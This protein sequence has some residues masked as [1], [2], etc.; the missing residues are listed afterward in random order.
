MTM[1]GLRTV[2]LG[3]RVLAGSFGR[4]LI[5]ENAMARL[6][7]HRFSPLPLNRCIASS[8]SRSQERRLSSS[9][10][11]TSSSYS[12]KSR[13]MQLYNSQMSQ[14]HSFLLLTATYQRS[15]STSTFNLTQQPS[16]P[17]PTSSPQPK[18]PLIPSIKSLTKHENIYT[19]PNI[20][21]FSR[22][23]VAPLVGYFTL[24]HQP[25]LA[26][27]LF[28]YAGFTDAVD[29]YLARR[30]NQQTVVGTVI[31]PMA[32][33]LLMTIAV[34]TLTMNG[35]FP[36]WLAVIILGRDVAL[37]I[38]AIYFRW[39]SLPPPK[40]MSRYWDF[41]LP[42]AEVHPTEI[43]KINTFLQLLLVG[44][45]MLLPVLPEALVQEWNLWGV[46]EGWMGLVGGT[47]IW[48]GL[49][50]IGNKDAVKILT[51][52]EGK[53]KQLDSKMEKDGK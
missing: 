29:G 19:I 12:C 10:G 1:S 43:S 21:T 36:V 33:K 52:E 50:Y 38:S 4:P 18:K 13:S 20:L 24:N 30:Y 3:R 9:F 51:R 25:I 44:N 5:L 31:D 41:S 27:S 53:Q 45:A 47:T 28:A 26:L 14:R 6:G 39:I 7:R 49:S 48:S 2:A 42:S 16:N 22:L 15:F 23:L 11:S 37:A 46:V 40:T 34:V 32:D 17:A 8:Q 35:T